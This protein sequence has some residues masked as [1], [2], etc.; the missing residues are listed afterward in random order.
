MK[1]EDK[2][3]IERIQ[4]RVVKFFERHKK[5]I[6][7]DDY[8]LVTKL[9]EEAIRSFEKKEFLN[10]K[11]TAN[12]SK[13][14]D[15]LLDGFTFQLKPE[16]LNRDS[17]NRFHCEMQ[18]FDFE[19]EHITLLNSWGNN[20]VQTLHNGIV[21]GNMKVAMKLFPNIF[22][23]FFGQA[24]KNQDNTLLD[25][26]NAF[27]QDGIFIYVPKGKHA[28]L[29]IQVMKL[30]DQVSKNLLQTRNLI[31][32]EPNSSLSLMDCDDSINHESNMINSVTEFFVAENAQLDVYKM[33]HINDNSVLINHS[34]VKQK[35]NSTV[36]MNTLSFNGGAIHNNIHVNL[37]G[38]GGNADV[39][40][41]Y[42]MDK[43][44]HVDNQIRINH[45][46]A[47]CNSSEQF[48]G[49]LDDEA[50]AVFNGYSYV[51][52]NAQKTNASQSNNNLLLTSKA[53]INTKPFLEIYADDV[54]CS[55]G[56]T[57][58][59]LDQEALF[60]MRSRGISAANARLLLM[61]AFAADIINQIRIEPLLLRVDD[62]VKKR[63]RGELSICDKCV[64]QCS[65]PQ[66]ELNFDIDM[67]KI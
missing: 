39:F 48:K 42:L 32:L 14:T 20:I 59:Q 52:P 26:N 62:L 22:E 56:A 13:L 3:S 34:F 7:K 66:K 53:R 4:N 24:I 29:P 15:F 38:E 5:T 58:G 18:D 67:S 33:Q 44:Q 60:Y 57:V 61:Y 46:K 31:I 21:I 49:I 47:H 55:H 12:H 11:T 27:W 45:N 19:S 17:I 51:A 41:L 35:A 2:K 37:D 1:T 28:T 10:E 23:K 8:E 36:R 16:N 9:R 40:G 25:L 43:K 54:K 65:K 63:L 50:T 6:A 30:V 64:L